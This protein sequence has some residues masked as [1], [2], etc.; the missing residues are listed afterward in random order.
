MSQVIKYFCAKIQYSAARLEKFRSESIQELKTFQLLLVK[1]Y[2]EKFYLLKFKIQSFVHRNNQWK[3]EFGD[4]Y[5][6]IEKNKEKSQ[7]QINQIFTTIA[8]LHQARRFA[9]SI[10]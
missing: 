7:Y 5:F 2:F 1:F 8:N 10:S 3:M 4:F 6:E 9:I